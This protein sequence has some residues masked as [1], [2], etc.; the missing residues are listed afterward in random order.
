MQLP[1]DI[2]EE[3]EEEEVIPDDA[4]LFPFLNPTRNTGTAHKV[5]ETCSI[6]CRKPEKVGYFVLFGYQMVKAMKPAKLKGVDQSSCVM[7]CSQNIVGVCCDFHVRFQESNGD[8]RN[9]TSVNYD[10]VNEECKLYPNSYP[11]EHSSLLMENKNVIFA[12]KFC[13]KCTYS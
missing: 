11:V 1:P 10:P 2:A 9:C 8:K 4:V 5:K 12:D 6:E 3:F 7:Y 13:V